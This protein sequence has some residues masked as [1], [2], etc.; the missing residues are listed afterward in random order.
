[1]KFDEQLMKVGDLVMFNDEGTY[2]K[3]F[4]GQFATVESVTQSIATGDWHC[5]VRWLSPVRYHDSHTTYSDFKV[6][7]FKVYAN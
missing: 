2:A 6:N 4:F 1:M 7:N 5:R 3:W